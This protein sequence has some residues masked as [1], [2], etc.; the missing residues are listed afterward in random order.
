M[1]RRTVLTLL[2]MLP[3]A[4]GAQLKPGIP[5]PGKDYVVLASPQP[6]WGVGGIEVAEVF[7]YT[8]IH[9]ANFQPLVNAWKK[10]LPADVKFRYVPSAFGGVNDNASRAYFA[11][12]ALGVQ[13][14]THDAIFKAVFIDK[15]VKTGS[16]E[17]FADVYAALGVDRAKMLAVMNGTT[18]SAKLNRAR[19]FAARTGVNGT[20]MLI[21]NGKYRIT[22]RTHEDSLRV[23]EYLIAKERAALPAA[24]KK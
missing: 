4:A 20:P 9:C 15:K 12:E 1:I 24:A 17:D 18:V 6:T 23:A 19:Q 3:F 22:A 8:C 16:L 2:L 5:M 7:N 10:K 14:R 21:V 13:E 11:A